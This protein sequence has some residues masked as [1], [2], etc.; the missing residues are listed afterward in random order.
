ML[1]WQPLFQAAQEAR[2]A[3]DASGRRRPGTVAGNDYAEHMDEVPVHLVVLVELAALQT[4]FPAI[5]ESSFAT[6]A[7]VYPFVQNLALAL[8][9][10]GLG[11]CLTMMLNNAEHQVRDL[12]SIPDGYALA[13]HLGVGVPDRHPTRLR[14]RPVGDFTTVDRFDGQ[15]FTES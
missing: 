1:T 14:R 13:A 7:S 15:P 3:P 11:S 5:R 2:G 10:E 4:P 9:A 12:L 8:R 6:G